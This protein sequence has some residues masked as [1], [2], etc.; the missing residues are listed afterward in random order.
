M[1]KAAAML[2]RYLIGNPIDPA[3]HIDYQQRRGWQRDELRTELE[4]LKAMLANA[5]L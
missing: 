3:R 4:Q 2:D 1:S 5:T